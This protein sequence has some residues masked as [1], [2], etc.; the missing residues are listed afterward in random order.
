MIWRDPAWSA[1]GAL[2]QLGGSQFEVALFGEVRGHLGS[3]KVGLAGGGGV[4]GSFEEVGADGFEAVGVGHAVLGVE[5]AEQGRR[6][7]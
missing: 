2:E 1:G 6:S 5:G 4:A 7:D 3:A